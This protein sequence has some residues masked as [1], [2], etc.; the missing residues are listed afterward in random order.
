MDMNEEISFV[1]AK[2]GKSPVFSK[3]IDIRMQGRGNPLMSR[4]RIRTMDEVD[5]KILEMR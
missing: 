5:K 2:I 3:E 1:T 4:K